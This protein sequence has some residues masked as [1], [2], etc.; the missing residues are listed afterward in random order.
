MLSC[1]TLTVQQCK[2]ECFLGP[3][4]QENFRQSRRVEVSSNDSPIGRLEAVIDV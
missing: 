2:F 4:Y 1:D 3:Q